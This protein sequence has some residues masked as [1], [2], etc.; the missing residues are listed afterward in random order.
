MKIKGK[1][2]GQVKEGYGRSVQ[3]RSKRS[4]YAYTY[5]MTAVITK[6]ISAC[7]SERLFSQSDW[8]HLSG[9]PVAAVGGAGW[10]SFDPCSAV[11]R[12]SLPRRPFSQA[13]RGEGEAGE[14]PLLAAR[15]KQL[16]WQR[17]G[18]R[19]PTLSTSGFCWTQRGG[20]EMIVS[21]RRAACV[22]KCRPEWYE[23]NKHYVMWCDCFN[24][25]CRG[26]RGTWRRVHAVF[27]PPQKK[28][29]EN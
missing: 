2:E 29:T 16:E 26:N 17:Q 15:Q 18:Q 9:V 11:R 20:I 7:A 1:S 6:W 14:P 19:S 22:P 27:P 13:G 23:V 5:G 4:K 3:F 21:E 10:I 24:A 25:I 12:S 28:K 8:P